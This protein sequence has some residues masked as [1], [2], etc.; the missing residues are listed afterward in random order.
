MMDLFGWAKNP[1]CERIEMI[2]SYI[3]MTLIYGERSWINHYPAEEVVRRRTNS[4]VK[5]HVIKNHN[6][7]YILLLI[8]LNRLWI[9]AIIFM[10]TKRTFLTNL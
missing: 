3:P 7:I 4:Y 9:Q 5:F 10:Q 8:I 2:E 6:C 1:L